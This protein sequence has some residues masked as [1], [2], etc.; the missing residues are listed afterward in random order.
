MTC[1]NAIQC[2]ENIHKKIIERF[3]QL[4]QGINF[5][6]SVKHEQTNHKIWIFTYDENNRHESEVRGELI[7]TPSDI[8]Q[9]YTGPRLMNPAELI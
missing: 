3:P 8:A 4:E 7:L 1:K 9:K 2:S 6:I 5:H